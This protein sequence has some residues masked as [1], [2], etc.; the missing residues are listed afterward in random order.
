MFLALGIF[1]AARKTE[2]MKI[3]AAVARE[4]QNAFS[5][6]TVDIDEPRPDEILVKIVGV[7]LC[8]TDI[9]AKSGAIG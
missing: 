9:V 1:P 6:E 8:H 4:N 3:K 7:G 5:I 2:V